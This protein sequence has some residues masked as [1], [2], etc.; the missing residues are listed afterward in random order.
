VA[1]QK[2]KTCWFDLG[3]V[4]LP[5]NFTPAYK[6]LGSMANI[7][8]KAVEQYF[9]DRPHFEADLDEGRL[10]AY[11]LY[12]MLKKEFKIKD[13]RY[14]EFKKIWNDIF[15][16]DAL[17]NKTLRQ[18]KSSG[19]KLILIS[20]TNKL[21]FDH[22]HKTY[23]IMSQFDG[24]ILSYKLKTR[25][26][27]RDIYESALKISKAQPQHIFYTDDRADLILAAKKNHGV[28]AHTFTTASKLRA[29]LKSKGVKL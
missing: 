11:Q 6:T 5:F 2:I 3:N 21:H 29:A 4:I 23:P 20:N 17:V 18:L 7:R 9:I 22:I 27:S 16:E 14:E 10:H 8:P 13:L 28:H 12:R 15:K 19:I 1:T 24:F 26:P 25:K